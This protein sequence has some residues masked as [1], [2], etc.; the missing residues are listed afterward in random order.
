MSA[1]R[2]RYASTARASSDVQHASDHQISRKSRRVYGPRVSPFSKLASACRLTHLPRRAQMFQMSLYFQTRSIL[3]RCSEGTT[4][5]GRSVFFLHQNTFTGSGCLKV[6]NT[7]ICGFLF[8]DDTLR[9]FGLLA[10]GSTFA[11][12]GYLQRH[13]TLFDPGLL[14]SLDPLQLPGFLDDCDS[15][16]SLGVHS[17]HGALCHSLH[18]MRSLTCQSAR[19]RLIGA[20]CGFSLQFFWF[21]S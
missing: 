7:L 6:H 8:S 13:N 12:Y 2:S 17:M 4:R 20:S 14:P 21:S 18:S 19:F 15:L 5:S 11:Q 16:G 10:A 3:S 1:T 9:S